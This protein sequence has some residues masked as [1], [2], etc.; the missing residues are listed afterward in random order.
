MKWHIRQHILKPDVTAKLLIHWGNWYT[1]N[2]KHIQEQDARLK[3]SLV[4]QQGGDSIPRQDHGA[5]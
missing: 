3:I 1:K 5:E 2:V 4:L